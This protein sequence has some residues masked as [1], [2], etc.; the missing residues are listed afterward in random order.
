MRFLPAKPVRLYIPKFPTTCGSSTD[1]YSRMLHQTS[2]GVAWSWSR[3]L[4]LPEGSTSTSVPTPEGAASGMAMLPSVVCGCYHLTCIH[5]KPR[6]RRHQS[7][8][9]GV[10][11][12]KEVAE[13]RRRLRREVPSHQLGK[14][15]IMARNFPHIGSKKQSNV[16][17][18]DEHLKQYWRRVYVGAS[19]MWSKVVT[20]RVKSDCRIDVTHVRYMSIAAIGEPSPDDYKWPCEDI[21]I[22]YCENVL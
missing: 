1:W 17:E 20:S 18:A 22:M 7:H 16:L 15:E 13:D 21:M 12:L 9:E 10:V 19:S 2:H 4:P 3:R 11:F 14:E 6:V 8:P 5:H